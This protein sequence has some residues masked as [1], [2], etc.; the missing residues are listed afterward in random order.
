MWIECR[1]R[2]RAAGGEDVFSIRPCAGDV[3]VNQVEVHARASGNDYDYD[4]DYDYSSGASPDP[5]RH[6]TMRSVIRQS[7]LR[8]SLFETKT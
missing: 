6:G 5:L 3:F 8:K 4:Y 7:D 2:P 1:C